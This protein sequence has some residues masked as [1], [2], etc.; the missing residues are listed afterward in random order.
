[1]NPSYYPNVLSY[2]ISLKHLSY[3]LSVVL[4][5]HDLIETLVKV[6]EDLVKVG[7]VRRCIM[8]V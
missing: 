5:L 3:S 7:R 2:G 1:M 6:S 8:E 4:V